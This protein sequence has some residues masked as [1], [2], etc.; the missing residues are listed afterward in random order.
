MCK[1]YFRETI[2]SLCYQCFCESPFVS[3]R[4]LAN[5]ICENILPQILPR[6]TTLFRAGTC[7]EQNGVGILYLQRSK[8]AHFPGRQ[9]QGTSNWCAARRSFSILELKVSFPVIDFG[10]ARQSA[11]TS[12]AAAST[13][14]HSTH[15][16]RTS[17]NKKKRVLFSPASNFALMS[18]SRSWLALSG[19]DFAASAPVARNRRRPERQLESRLETRAVGRAQIIATVSCFLSRRAKKEIHGLAPPRNG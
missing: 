1:K 19:S 3:T 14:L 7:V 18:P 17:G 2:S 16:P 12:A 9:M 11:T 10:G 13:P 5:I 6:Q 15:N 8:M 4:K